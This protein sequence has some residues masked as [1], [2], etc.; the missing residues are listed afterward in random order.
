MKETTKL[1]A[2]FGDPVSHS[3]SP[4]MH[5]YALSGLGIDACYTRYRLEDGN[6]LR[7]KF[8]DLK[9]EGI[10]VTV[11][12]KEAAYEACD[13][14]RGIA[15]EIGAINTIVQEKG[16]LIGYNTDAPGFLKSA[17]LFGK[18][19]RVCILGAGGTARALAVA[20]ARDGV[21]VTMLNRSSGRLAFFKAKGFKTFTWD[22]WHGGS[23]D[24]VVNTTSA[25][26][27]DNTLPAPQ[28]IVEPLLR[29][30]RFAIDVVYNK[31]TPFI[32]LAEKIGTPVKD[33]SEMLLFQGVYALE[34]FLGKHYSEERLL[35]W[36]QKAFL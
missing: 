7:Q 26:L 2:I 16:R 14:I 4:L 19:D 36:M 12:H 21:D 23:F 31:K 33:G 22:T 32:K 25:G 8:F 20:F 29:E 17:H 11:P 15:S 18:I 3:I 9:L 30:S 6:K 13:Q 5:N 10:N 27:I 34:L 35:P 28:E 24:L 1:F